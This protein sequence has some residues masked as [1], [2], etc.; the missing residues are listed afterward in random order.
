M[1]GKKLVFFF[2]CCGQNHVL[3]NP[4]RLSDFGEHD[5]KKLVGMLAEEAS[6]LPEEASVA[7]YYHLGVQKLFAE[8]VG[9]EFCERTGGR[10]AWCCNEAPWGK[11]RNIIGYLLAEGSPLVDPGDDF[12]RRIGIAV[13]VL[14]KEGMGQL[15][16]SFGINTFNVFGGTLYRV[17]YPNGSSRKELH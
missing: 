10:R 12:K 13:F 8:K 5:A 11:D 15:G 7:I 16:A 14:N 3:R 6:R 9:L 4:D 2:F 1:H 17:E